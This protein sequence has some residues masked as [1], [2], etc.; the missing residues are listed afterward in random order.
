[1]WGPVVSLAG[2]AGGEAPEA[3]SASPRR[4]WA[5]LLRRVFA[6]DPERCPACGRGTLR[7]IAA[8][9]HAEVIRK[10]LRYLELTADPPPIAP[11]RACQAAFAWASP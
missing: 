11:A 1:M 8:I 4:G 5:R 6:F 9:I 10:I 7:I 3:G 2:E